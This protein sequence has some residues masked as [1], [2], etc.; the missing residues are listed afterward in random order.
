MPWLDTSVH[1]QPYGNIS[2]GLGS[3]ARAPVPGKGNS[4]MLD[5][6]QKHF[7][8]FASRFARWPIYSG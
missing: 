8:M 6:E 7:G 5:A 2:E 1:Q 3:R 4:Q